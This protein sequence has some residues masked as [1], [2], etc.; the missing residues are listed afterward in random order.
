M[1]L[2]R[3]M[4]GD[5]DTIHSR[6]ESFVPFHSPASSGSRRPPLPFARTLIC[7]GIKFGGQPAAG[8]AEELA[9]GRDETASASAESRRK[10][11]LLTH[12]LT[13]RNPHAAPYKRLKWRRQHE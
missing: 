6:L 10:K 9:S 2:I 13:R 8:G 7:R 5:G 12:N 1:Q 11:Q 3:R 4:R